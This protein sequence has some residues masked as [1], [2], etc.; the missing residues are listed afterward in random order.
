MRFIKNGVIAIV[1]V[2]LLVSLS[3]SILS[4][5]D[6]IAF[7]KEYE[8]EYAKELETYKQLKGELKK[9]SDSYVVEKDIREKLQLLKPNEV[10]VI[11]PT[12]SVQPS[13]SPT[14]EKKPYQEWVDLLLRK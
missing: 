12:I 3:K 10:A 14:P 5:K 4:Y 8:K 13:P 1:A 6:K 11:L 2:L 7:N 9:S